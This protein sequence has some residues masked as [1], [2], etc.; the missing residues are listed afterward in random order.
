MFG[1]VESIHNK[2][3]RPRRLF[4]KEWRKK[5]GL[6][7]EQVAGRLDTDKGVISKLENGGQRLTA[8]WIFGIAEALDIDP[9]QLFHHPDQPTVNDLL[10]NTPPALR[11]HILGLVTQ[12]AK[13]G[14]SG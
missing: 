9:E 11:D 1:V 10:R 4:V 12:L 14:T 2:S 5:R 7:Q 13:T 8:E 6:T 3:G